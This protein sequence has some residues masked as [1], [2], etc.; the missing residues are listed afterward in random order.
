MFHIR[1]I[2]KRTIRPESMQQSAI[3]MKLS[4]MRSDACG[5]SREQAIFLDIYTYFTRLSHVVK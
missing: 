4:L 5:V 2:L 3:A 1:R